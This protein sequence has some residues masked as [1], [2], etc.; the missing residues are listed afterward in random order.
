MAATPTERLDLGLLEIFVAVAEQASFSKASRSLGVTKGTA[1][2]AVARL[3]RIVGA[4][5]LHRDTH[6]VAMSTAGIA[7]FERAAPHLA[8]LAGAVSDLPEHR[9]EPAGQ[10]RITAS[11]DFGLTMLPVIVASFSL[12]FPAITFDIRLSNDVADL[13]AE[14]FDLSIRAAPRGL[15]DSSLTVRKLGTTELRF[16]GSP[17]Y[18]ARR[19][20][21]REYGD[22]NHDWIVFS[23]STKLFKPKSGASIRFLSD[24]LIFVRALAIAD[25]GIAALPPFVA[26]EEVQ[27]GRLVPVMQS[28]TLRAPGGYFLLYPTR[29]QI[30]RKV[31]AFRD[32]LVNCM[33]SKPLAVDAGS[34]TR[35]HLR[36]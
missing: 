36:S 16:Y 4:E 2:R 15:S 6:R 21:P 5:L 31:S 32:F 3:E 9:E 27:A 20:E 33:A 11:H 28:R 30:S 17:R 23:P 1:S 24:N 25:G 12:R 35:Q 14:G 29:G 7:L 8:A 34:A 19:G 18:V 26:D 10:L 13:V 22:L